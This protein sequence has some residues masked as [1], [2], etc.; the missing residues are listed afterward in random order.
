MTSFLQ[1]LISKGWNI[2]AVIT[3]N[4]WLEVDTVKDLKIYEAM[5]KEN[6]LKQLYEIPKHF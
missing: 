4:G 3:E 5:E 6:T 1:H 2:K